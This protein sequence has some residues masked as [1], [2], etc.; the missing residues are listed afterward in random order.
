M[1]FAASIPA[2]LKVR[3][4]EKKWI[5]REALRDWLP[6]DVLDRPKQGFTPP[7]GHWFRNELRELSR[8]V[9]RDEQSMARSYFKPAE[10]RAMLDRHHSGQSDETKRLWALFVLELWHREFVD[11][12]PSSTALEEAAAA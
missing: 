12:A 6:G 9:L 8:D 7:V 5:L 1:E 11:G 10:V 2:E 4:R 3:G